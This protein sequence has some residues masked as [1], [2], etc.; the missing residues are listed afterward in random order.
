MLSVTAAAQTKPDPVIKA[1][2]EHYRHGTQLYDLGKYVDAAKEYEQAFQLSDKAAFLYNI[3]QAYRLGGMPKEA[4][5]AYR[6]FVRREA[7]SSLR[8]Q[9]EDYIAEMERAVAERAA[10]ERRAEAAAVNPVLTTTS[11]LPPP[12]KP[13]WKRPWFWGAIAASAVVVVGVGVGVGVGLQS[14]SPQPNY[15]VTF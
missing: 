10:A 15:V 3:G 5:A 6:G 12:Q 2:R 8:A 14:H 9:A 7:A 11:P 4:L 1:A 13:V